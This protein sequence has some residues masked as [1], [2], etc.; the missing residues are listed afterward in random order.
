MRIAWLGW[1]MGVGARLFPGVFHQGCRADQPRAQ[2]KAPASHLSPSGVDTPET[3]AEM[4][5]FLVTEFH[6]PC[7]RELQSF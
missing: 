1:E 5:P 2:C 3:H 4:V 7:I 6:E